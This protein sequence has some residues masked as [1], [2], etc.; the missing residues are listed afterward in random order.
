MAS[1]IRK[2]FVVEINYNVIVRTYFL[3]GRISD[4]FKTQSLFKQRMDSQCVALRMNTLSSE[5]VGGMVE[6]TARCCFHFCHWKFS[7]T[8]FPCIVREARY[9]LN[10]S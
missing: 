10:I 6:P 3:S 4:F 5:A 7:N 2:N 8:T 1:I 9:N